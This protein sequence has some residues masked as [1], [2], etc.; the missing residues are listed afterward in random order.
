MAKYVLSAA[1]AIGRAAT[2]DRSFLSPL[3]PVLIGPRAG[4]HRFAAV[5]ERASLGDYDKLADTTYSYPDVTVGSTVDLTSVKL[6]A[7][8]ANLVYFSKFVGINGSAQPSATYAN[9]VRAANFVFK[10]ANDVSRSAAFYDRDVAVGDTVVVSGTGS[11][12]DPYEV[13][14]LVTGFAGEAVAASTGTAAAEDN[15]A[16]TQSA[17]VNIG[18]V[19]DTPINDVIASANGA[20]YLSTADGYITRTY[21]ITVTQSSTGTDA[22]TARL[23][24]RS[25]DGLDN[26]D[27]VVPAAFASPT[28]IGS[29]GLT[30]TF[31]IDAGH[32]SG[33]EVDEDDLVV[34]QAWTVTVSQA[35][36]AVVATAAGTYTGTRTTNYIVTVSRG[37]RYADATKPQITITSSNGYDRSGPTTVSAAATPYAVGNYGVT[38]SF[39]GT[40]LRKGDVFY[41]TATAA[42]EGAYKTLILRDNIPSELVGEEVN[43]VLSVARPD[44]EIPLARTFPSDVTNWSFTDSTVKVES[45]ILIIDAEFTDGSD[46][47]PVELDTADLYVEY[48]EWLTA[49][50]GDVIELTDPDEIVAA[51][52]TVTSANPLAYAA[53]LALANTAGEL[54]NDPAKPTATTSDRI[55]CVTVG[56][57]PADLDL[58]QSALDLIESNEDAY[59]LVPLSTDP[60]VK[61]LFV[62]HVTER[63]G[64]TTG[65]YRTCWLTLPLVETGAVVAESTTT[66]GEAVTATIAATPATSPTAYTTLTASA[67]AAFVTKNVRAGDKVRIDF[68]ENAFGEA[69][70]T[71]YIVAA[72]L[73]QTTLRLATGPVAAIS[74]A[75]LIEVWR[76]YTKTE[77]GAQQTAAAAA[78]ANSRVKLVYPDKPA[79][80]GETLDGFYL[81]SALAAL[82]GS[83]PS[84][85]GLKNVGV[86]GFDDLTRASKFFTASQLDDLAAGGVFVVGQT[87][88]GVVYVHSAVTTDVSELATREEMVVRNADMVRKA[89]QD[90]WGPYVGAGNVVSN[91]GSLLNGALIS[92][93]M[94]LRSSNSVEQLGPPVADLSV[95]SIS[96]VPGQADVLDVTVN[97]VGLAVPLN[98]LHV[99]LPVSI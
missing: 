80:G 5:S 7:G 29:K 25:A 62:T 13:T 86:V 28:A 69:T 41:V 45:G 84:Q 39:A 95:A 3:R 58:W 12:T 51:L 52:G 38:M 65:L 67:N 70:Y 85:Q 19:A 40:Y 64:D 4:L 59:G 20:A 30:V 68:S 76:T 23:R 71:E 44:L 48:R 92:L 93:S 18:Q 82:A 57:D 66:D 14:S 35:F 2:I 26:A 98:Q 50:A 6:F 9:R 79:F 49:G 32:S 27:N 37:G 8:T 1:S 78:Y 91:M 10:T 74:V 60:A 88:L 43:I 54:L 53:S 97:Q 24:V 56:G 90:E 61:D 31:S 34:G 63:S 83:V 16:D 17:A 42:G 22:T 94:R 11:D 33:S 72:V 81:C 47:V 87:P 89:I 96:T 77:L 75:R 36:A 73:S 46:P 15:N 99:F 21:T 55:L